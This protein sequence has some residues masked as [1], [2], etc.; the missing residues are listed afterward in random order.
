MF[1]Q[2]P[3][4]LIISAQLM[5]L[6]L[7]SLTA[8]LY[9]IQKNTSFF[10]EWNVTC[11]N[12]LSLDVTLLMDWMALMF[13]STVLFISSMVSFY[14]NSYMQEDKSKIRFIL[15]VTCFVLSMALLILSP[16]L[17]NVL[18]GWDG[19]GLVSYCLVI[20]YQNSKSASAGMITA[21]S[22]R[23]GDVCLIISLSLAFYMGSF[24]FIFWTLQF[25][26]NEMNMI[27]ITLIV[28]AATTK[29]SANSF[30]CLTPR[31]YSR[32]DP[33]PHALVHSSTLVT[34][35]VYLLIRFSPMIQEYNMSS[36]LLIMSTLTMFMAGLS[37]NFEFDL[38]KIIALSTL[39]QLGVMM[40]SISLGMEML[41]FFHLISHALFK[42]LL[43][44]SAGLLIHNMNNTQDIRNLGSITLMFP[45][46]SVVMNMANLSLCGFPFLAGF[47][48][49]DLIIEMNLSSNLNLFITSLLLISTSLTAI[50]S[51]RLTYFSMLNSFL[52][53]SLN[54]CQEKDLHMNTP[55][56]LMGV[57][58]IVSGAS[59]MWLTLP[60]PTVIIMPPVMKISVTLMVLSSLLM[61]VS[62]F[63]KTH[64]NQSL[65]IW[66]SSSMWF[67]PQTSSFILTNPFMKTSKMFLKNQDQGWTEKLTAQG[68]HELLTLNS[69]HLQKI[70]N[71]SIK[72]FLI[73][74]LALSLPLMLTLI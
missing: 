25:N 74:F 4:Y 9:L 29:K 69:S 42:A 56:Y 55:M 48:S 16:N 20:Y 41:A 39:S 66:F 49:K 57:L 6:S 67:L 40:F 59:L 1:W 17:V 53:M 51:M 64:I 54:N 50:Y 58:S 14:S 19:L 30:L 22:N 35:G 33:S 62:L 8:G 7:A 36:Y 12:S 68:A 3:W 38:K 24:N 60:V 43:F 34:A 11:W 47:Y 21:L 26:N 2:I 70:Q 63:Q 10:L 45:L 52:N 32:P 73:L 72:I 44:L 15:L 18:L 23:I 71:N 27:I 65:I 46:T 31:S 61:G 5:V 28:I 37:A 13:L